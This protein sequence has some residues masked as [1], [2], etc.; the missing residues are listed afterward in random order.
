M[1]KF[2]AFKISG[3][4]GK[5]PTRTM[6]EIDAELVFAVMAMLSYRQRMV[7]SLRYFEKM[8][9]STIARILDFGYLQTV[10]YLFSVKRDL[11]KHI[12]ALGL[13]SDSLNDFIDLFGKLTAFP[14]TQ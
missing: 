8:S 9:L 5:K 12:S 14:H 10:F 11:K 13:G 2:T 1:L 3:S 4:C 6:S 7:L